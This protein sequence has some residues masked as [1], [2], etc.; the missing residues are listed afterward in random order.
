MSTR[1]IIAIGG[2]TGALDALKHIFADLPADLPAAVFVVRHIAA[3]GGDMLANI[4]DAAGPIAVKTAAEGDLIKNGQAYV[5]P[6]GHHLLVDNG[7]I[8]LGQGPRENMVRPAVDP[9]FRSVALSYGPRVIAVV[10]SGMLDDGAAGLAAVKRCGGLTV[11]QDPADAEA[12][13]MPL[14]ALDA[15]DVD[16]RAPAGKLAQVLARL[17]K[18]P[19]PPACP[20]PGDIAL[21]V[22]IAAGRPS[23]TEGIARI[24]V[25]VALSCPSCSGV[26]SEIAEP[27]RLRFRCQI[28]HA[29]TASVLDKEQEAAVAEAVG[30]ALRVLEERH[31]L[32][33]K[34]ATDAERR[35]QK[36]SARQY[37]E[38]AAGFRQ[39]A[40]SI[41]KA[42]IDGIV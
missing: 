32:L 31:T 24:A 5:A 16:Y 41:R 26:L 35:G 4:L 28:G 30:I 13:D 27:S 42:A 20:V 17:T 14:S 15:C 39:Q 33:I 6:A 29:Y 10:L 37:T 40:D 2:S 22:Q 34:M 3:N 7:T 25:P 23:T 19:A 38:R 36:L 21:E 11:V 12:A 9:L 8:R 1:D 18:E